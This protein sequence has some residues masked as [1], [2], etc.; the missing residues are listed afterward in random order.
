MGTSERSN[1]FAGSGANT[2]FSVR[3]DEVSSDDFV[4][5]RQPCSLGSTMDSRVPRGS[6]L[7]LEEVNSLIERRLSEFRSESESSGKNNIE[8]PGDDAPRIPQFPFADANVSGGSK[9]V[10]TIKDFKNMQE[11]LE[12]LRSRQDSGLTTVLFTNAQL[13]FLKFL[14]QKVKKYGRNAVRLVLA[15]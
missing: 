2:M 13:K 10:V 1:S 15:L 8:K 4:A 3:S 12:L 14:L 9:D 6:L 11:E 7:T 5:G